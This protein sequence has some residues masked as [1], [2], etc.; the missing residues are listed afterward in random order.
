[1]K[2]IFYKL[3]RFFDAQWRL[4]VLN[5]TKGLWVV[6]ADNPACLKAHNARGHHILIQPAHPCEGYYMMADDLSMDHLKR[7]HQYAHTQWKPGRMI[8]ETSLGNFQVWIHSDRQLSVNEKRFW[9]QKMGSDPSAHP[10]HRWGRCPGF[11]NR[12]QQHRSPSGRFPLA[13]LIW[14]DWQNK[15]Q[16][17]TIPSDI[18]PLLPV[19]TTPQPL[20]STIRRFDYQRHNESITDFAYALALARR[21]VPREHIIQRI[22]EERHDWSHHLGSKRMNNYL[23][24]TVDKAITI[25]RESTSRTNSK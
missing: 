18:P 7:Q 11:F 3:H 23:D 16:I 12:K 14:V 5:D 9:L 15:A 8:V 22:L 19:S 24:R 17:P 2:Q 20:Q 6:S 4:A 21:G 25:I 1:V 10:Y 13:R